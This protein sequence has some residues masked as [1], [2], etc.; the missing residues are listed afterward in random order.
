MPDQGTYNDIIEKKVMG[1]VIQ[2][3][4]VGI[5]KDDC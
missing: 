4:G 2:P 5:W 3:T 1:H